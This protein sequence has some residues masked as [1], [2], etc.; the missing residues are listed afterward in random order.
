MNF[1]FCSKN[2]FKMDIHIL[3]FYNDIYKHRMLNDI[4]E[5]ISVFL[6]NIFEIYGK[7]VFYVVENIYNILYTSF[8]HTLNFYR[9]NFTDVNMVIIMVM[10]VYIINLLNKISHKN[11]DIMSETSYEMYKISKNMK[12][13]MYK[14][15]RS[16]EKI[17]DRSNNNDIIQFKQ[18]LKK[19]LE[20]DNDRSAKKISRINILMAFDNFDFDDDDIYEDV[21]KD[22][23]NI[24]KIKQH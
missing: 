13:D 24:R 14:I 15:L 23:M 8:I 7:I 18:K 17:N 11:I 6:F 22:L 2:K 9:S 10:F 12:N 4:H 5:S 20:N 3:K 1:Y 21:Q 16:I 19:I